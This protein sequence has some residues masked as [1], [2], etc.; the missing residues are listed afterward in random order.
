MAQTSEAACL[1]QTGALYTRRLGLRSPSG[2]LI[3]AGFKRGAFSLYFGD[4]PIYHFDLEGRWQRAYIQGIHYRKGLDTAIDAIDRVRE[5]ANL[6][7]RRRSPS[8]AEAADLDDAIRSVALNLIEGLDSGRWE[9]ADPPAQVRGISRDELRE[10]LERISR[11]DTAAWFAHRERYLGT[12]GPL[13][14]L[15]PDCPNAVVLQAT[16]GH[17]R[18]RAFGE[19]DPAEPYVRSASEFA[20]HARQVASLYGR[21]LSQTRNLF[22]AGRDLL[23]LSVDQVAADLAIVADTFPIDP[24]LARKSPRERPEDAAT[25][26]GIVA[27]LEEFAPP[28]LDRDDWARLRGLHLDRVALGVESGASEVRALYGKTW[29]EDDLRSTVADLKSAR[30]AISLLILAGAG[31]LEHAERHVSATADLLGGLDL[32]AGDFVYLLDIEE[33]GG[34]SARG[35]LGEKGLTALDSAAIVDQQ[36]RLKGTLSPLMKP[37]GAKVLPYSLEKQQA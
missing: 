12:Y 7:L 26:D 13:P 37:K 30:I 25:L 18:G 32:G 19:A 16:L 14:F 5:D 22:L 17:A 1:L 6:V 29:E 8:F 33:V 11:W 2:D 4:E 15:P 20:E 10:M 24:T 27:F 34:P 9:P 35:R 28:H 36:A 31:G 3:F 23:R 21:R